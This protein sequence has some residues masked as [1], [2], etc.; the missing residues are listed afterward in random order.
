MTFFTKEDQFI[1][2]KLADLLKN[3]GCEIPNWI[4]SLPK[5]D[6]K[7]FKK[8][9]KK[10]IKRENVLREKRNYKDKEFYKDIK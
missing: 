5:K 2:R 3:S 8:L 10:P 4:F 6:K 9:E 7:Y 1:V